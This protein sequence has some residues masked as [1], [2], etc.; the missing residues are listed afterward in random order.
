MAEEKKEK[1]YIP[2]D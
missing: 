1:K 2:L